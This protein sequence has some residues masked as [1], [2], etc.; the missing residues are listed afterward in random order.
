[1]K[2]FNYLIV[3]VAL[4]LIGV[5]FAQPMEIL[6]SERMNLSL[7]ADQIRAVQLDAK[8]KTKARLLRE[9]QEYEDKASD[10]RTIA[11]SISIS[12]Q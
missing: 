2:T 1:M 5:A 6:E 9:A 10:T 3:M 7:N 12:A 4:I 8:I 11:N